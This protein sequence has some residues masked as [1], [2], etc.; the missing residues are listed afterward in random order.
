MT[1]GL[2]FDIKKFSIHDGPGIRTTVFFKGCPLNCWWCHNPESQSPRMEMLLRDNRCIQCGACIEACPHDAILWLD[3]E[4]VTDRAL[5][6][7]CG[8]CQAACYADAR[9]RVGREMTVEQVMAEIKADVAFYDQSG[10]GVTFSGGEPLLQ[11]DFLL[12]V[13][14]ACQDQD[15][16][17]ALDTSGCAAWATLDEVRPCVDLFLYDLKV[18]DDEKHREFTGVSNRSILANLHALSERGHNIIIRVPV[19]PGINDDDETVRQIGAFAGALPHLNSVDLLPYHH[20]AIDKYLRL[21]KPYR[22]FETRQPSAERMTEIAQLLQS[23]NLSVTIG[24]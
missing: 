4:P 23:F 3:G 16:H 5:C 9:E 18:V 11:R 15:I 22:L 13:L 20:I 7:Q 12:D 1:H 24:G 8:T 19:I 10:G 17:T 21:N 2:I 14:R 6:A